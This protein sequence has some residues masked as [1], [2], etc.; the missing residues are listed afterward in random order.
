MPASAPSSTRAIDSTAEL[1][2]AP[3]L[4][5]YGL[6]F[7]ESDEDDKDGDDTNG[8][9]DDEPQAWLGADTDLQDGRLV[10][11]VVRR[12]TPAHAAGLN[13]G[14]EIIAIGDDRVPPD[15]LGDRLEAY[16]PG[17]E[18]DPPRR[19]ARAPGTAA[20]HLRGEA[21]AAAGRSSPTP[22]RRPSSGSGST[23]GWERSRRPS[24]QRP[25]REPPTPPPAPRSP[26][27]RR[28]PAPDRGGDRPSGRPAP[29][30]PG[31]AASAAA[32]PGRASRR[33]SRAAPR[34]PPPRP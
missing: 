27:R 2:Y 20:R 23:P 14:D 6:R 11:T 25:R 17:E 3:A 24:G 5:W 26:P 13:V 12:G 8:K 31:G 30:R 9:G 16:R 4:A 32:H 28:T 19:P 15:G 33:R 10:V 22:R 1:D 18:V 34:A 7:A 29:R 21:E